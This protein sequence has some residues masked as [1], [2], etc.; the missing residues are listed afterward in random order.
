MNDYG[1]RVFAKALP[2]NPDFSKV[3][4]AWILVYARAA[5]SDAASRIVTDYL[6]DNSWEVIRFEES[7]QVDLQRSADRDRIE[8]GLVAHGV[9]ALVG[10]VPPSDARNFS[11]N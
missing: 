4:T 6:N 11:L 10:G 1:A 3:D 2:D 7:G 8:A 9:F 5:T